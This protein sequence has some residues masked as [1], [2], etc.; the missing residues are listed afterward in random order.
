MKTVTIPKVVK[1]EYF[2]LGNDNWSFKITL[3]NGSFFHGYESQDKNCTINAINQMIGSIFEKKLVEVNK[4][5]AKNKAK[6][7][8]V[9]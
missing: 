9:K 8:K 4:I 7:N 6:K 3:D 5:L 2:F 1:S